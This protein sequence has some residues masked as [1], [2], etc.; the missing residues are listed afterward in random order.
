M[1]GES[2]GSWREPWAWRALSLR[3]VVSLQYWIERWD[4]DPITNIAGAGPCV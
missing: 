4:C 3:A 2:R 1:R